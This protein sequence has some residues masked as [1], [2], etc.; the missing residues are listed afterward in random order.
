MR[1]LR[2]R[3]KEPAFL[4]ICW[5]AHRAEKGTVQATLCLAHRRQIA[6]EH[7]EVWGCGQLGDSCDLCEGRKP[8]RAD[9]E[10]MA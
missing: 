6:L 5:E 1:P 3:S 9:G 4:T 7:P 10:G 8:R 2:P